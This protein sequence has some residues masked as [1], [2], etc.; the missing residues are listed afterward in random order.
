MFPSIFGQFVIFVFVIKSNVVLFF[1]NTNCTNRTNE[2]KFPSI[3][4][5]FVI[6]V[7]VIKTNVVFFEHELTELHE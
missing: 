7:F 2:L 6:F 3:F 1:L 5:Q 4:G